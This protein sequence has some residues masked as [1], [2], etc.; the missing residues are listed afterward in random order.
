MEKKEQSKRALEDSKS[1]LLSVLKGENK[2]TLQLHPFQE[3]RIEETASWSDLAKKVFWINLYNAFGQ[4][5][6]NSGSV[7]IDK[8]LFSQRLIHFYDLALSLDEIEHGILR[9]GKWKK[10][11]GYLPGYFHLKSWKVKK[12]DY[13]VHFV[14]NCAAESCPIIRPFEIESFAE[15]LARA[16]EDFILQ[17]TKYDQVNQIAEISSLFLFYRGDF[18]GRKGIRLLLNQ[19]VGPVKS[20]TYQSFDWKPR[21]GKTT[22]ESQ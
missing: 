15:E 6:L 20:W 12:L 2:W 9:G 17:T 18:G 22:Y 13:R 4:L 11:L 5:T 3:F 7:T 16:E 1:F 21:Y 19:F 10:A 8:N 14:L